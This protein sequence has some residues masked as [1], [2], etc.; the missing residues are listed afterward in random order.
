MVMNPVTSHAAISS[1]GELTSRAISA[2]TMKMPEPIIEPITSVVALVRPSPFTNSLSPLVRETV[3]V[4]VL[5]RPLGVGKLSSEESTPKAAGI[6]LLPAA[7]N[8]AGRRLPPP[9]PH[10]PQLQ[11]W[12]W[13]G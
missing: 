3:F 5:N 6:L 12:R 13:Y 7:E 1:A 8:S 9:S 10:L 11:T 4:S 2:E